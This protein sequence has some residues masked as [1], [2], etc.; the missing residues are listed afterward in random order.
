MA[1]L[2]LDTSS[3]QLSLAIAHAGQIHAR[4]WQVGQKHA[5][6]TLPALRSLLTELGLEMAAI[7][8]IAYPQGPG[9]FTGLRIGCGIA[10]GLAFARNLP[11]VG[12]STLLALAERSGAL[13]AYVCIDARMN[14]VYTAAYMRTALD[15]PWQMVL[16]EQVCDPDAVPLPSGEGWFGIGTGFAAYA[17]ALQERLGAQL[18]QIAASEQANA[19]Q[20]LQ[21]ALPRFASGDVQPAHEANLVYLRDKVALKTSERV[22]K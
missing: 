2:A 12:V 9:S 18:S 14:Q 6:L 4:V 16:E 21:L 17:Q 3:E 22:A 8:G 20:L 11:V 10:Q 15:K 1:Y 13:Q 5:E 19:E 7:T